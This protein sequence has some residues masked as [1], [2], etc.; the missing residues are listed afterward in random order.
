[1]VCREVWS[2]E[3]NM[4]ATNFSRAAAGL[5]KEATGGILMV[6]AAAIALV[7]ANSPWSEQYFALRDFRIGYSPWGLDLSF[8]QWAADGLLAIFFFLVGLELKQEIIAG[9]LRNPRRAA[10]PM[11]AAA[12]G[13]IVPALIYMAATASHPALHHGWAIPTA[14]DITFAVAILALVGSGLP[15]SLRLFLLT[16]AV[17]DDLIAVVIIAF[18]YT[19]GIRLVP[20]LISVTVI[21]LYWLIAHRRQDLFGLNLF[22]AWAILF[23]I[24]LVAWGFMHASGV[25]ATIAG[26]ALGL[27][28]P[29]R[30]GP[31]GRRGWGEDGSGLAGEFERRFRPLSNLVAVP[32]FA[33]FA[34]GVALGGWGGLGEAFGSPVTVAVI[35]ALV[36]GKPIGILAS[37]WVAAKMVGSGLPKGSRWVDMVGIAVLAGVGFTVAL[38]VAELSFASGSNEGEYAKIAI[39]AASLVAAALASAILIPRSR[40]Y[41]RL[42]G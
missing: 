5:R 15:S 38:L 27:C 10:V 39:L 21:A 32:V 22:A 40:H 9:D 26:V 37:T 12:G 11:V 34:A 28:I 19:D 13:V 42:D 23:P 24:G 36:F 41:R 29:V 6:T 14:T 3:G 17:M 20:L 2:A 8:G 1:M 4:N 35:I 16:L 33:F 18:F 31:E 30:P 25:H 7:W